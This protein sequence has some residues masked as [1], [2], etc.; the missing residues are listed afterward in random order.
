MKKHKYIYNSI[1]S[2]YRFV[3]PFKYNPFSV[4]IYILNNFLFF[5]YTIPIQVSM[6]NNIY[7]P[8]N[9][10]VGL[11]IKFNILHYLYTL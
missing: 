10:F 7:K 4:I 9:H 1:I 5:Y 6:E 11:E 2:K 8:I 3:T